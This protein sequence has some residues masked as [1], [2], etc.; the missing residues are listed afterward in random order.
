MEQVLNIDGI[1]GVQQMWS[2]P[3]KII[4][5]TATDTSIIQLDPPQILDV[6]PEIEKSPLL[7]AGL[8]GETLI[9]VTSESVTAWDDVVNGN[10]AAAW[11]PSGEITAAKVSGNH[12]AVSTKGKVT[13]LSFDGQF[14]NVV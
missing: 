8:A 4:I 5:S 6:C 10:K 7:A 9:T 1:E 3:G 2:T 11:V 12:V 13:V 14:N